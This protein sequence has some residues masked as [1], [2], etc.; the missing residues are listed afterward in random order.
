MVCAIGDGAVST[1]QS[2]GGKKR[3]RWWRVRDRLNAGPATAYKLTTI[4]DQLRDPSPLQMNVLYS[5]T[6]SLRSATPLHITS[7]RGT[8]LHYVRTSFNPGSP[9][10]FPKLPDDRPSQGFYAPL[11][12]VLW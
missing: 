6:I 8:V 7:S 4:D 9:E 5:G 12:H 1:G 3:C 10:Q 11:S 2:E